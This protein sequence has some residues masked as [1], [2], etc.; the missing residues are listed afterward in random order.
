MSIH[1]TQLFSLLA[2]QGDSVRLS[3]AVAKAESQMVSSGEKN[4]WLFWK[5]QSLLLLD[6]LDEIQALVDQINDPE[7]AERLYQILLLAK[8]R[9]SGNFDNLILHLEEKVRTT[10]DS[11]NLLQLCE[12]YYEAKNWKGIATHAKALVEQIGTAASLHLAVEGAVQAGE[13]RLCLELLEGKESLFPSGKLPLNLRRIQIFSWRNEG[14]LNVAREQAE[15]LMLETQASE[16]LLTFV[17]LQIESADLKGAAIHSRLLL[18]R[19]DILPLQHLRLARAFQL[20]DPIIAGAHLDKALASGDRSAEFAVEAL[21]LIFRLNREKAFPELQAALMQSAQSG[22]KLQPVS[23][24]RLLEM[25]KAQSESVQNAQELYRGGRIPLHFLAEIIHSTLSGIYQVYFDPSNSP[26]QTHPWAPIF[27]R[28]GGRQLSLP[29]APIQKLYLDISALIIAHKLDLLDILE[30]TFAPCYLPAHAINAVYYQ[31][32]RAQQHQPSK[33]DEARIVSESVQTKQISLMPEVHLEDSLE[34]GSNSTPGWRSAMNFAQSKNG[35]LVTFL[36]ATTGFPP[37]PMELTPD[38]KAR[39]IDSANVFKAMEAAGKLTSTEI[40]ELRQRGLLQSNF[41]SAEVK[42]IPA[43]TDLILLGVQG[44]LAGSGVLPKI[45]AQ[46]K[47][48]IEPIEAERMSATLR[49]E[50]ALSGLRASLQVLLHKLESGL[51]SKWILLPSP[52]DEPEQHSPESNCILDLSRA[53]ASPGAYIWFDDRFLNGF[54]QCGSVPTTSAYEILRYLHGTQALDAA[55]LFSKLHLLREA[56]LRY[57]PIEAD[58]IIHHLAKAKIHDNSIVETPELTLLRR[59]V[60]TCLLQRDPFQIPPVAEGL[61]NPAGELNFIMQVMEAS[62]QAIASVWSQVDSNNRS[63]I[64]AKA[65]WIVQALWYD[66]GIL[67]WLIKQSD[68]PAFKSAL[69]G[70]LAPLYAQ[71]LSLIGTVVEEDQSKDTK[72]ALYFRWLSQRFCSDDQTMKAV[73]EFLRQIFVSD[74]MERPQGSDEQEVYKR[75]LTRFFSD[76]PPIIKNSLNL[77]DETL[78]ELRITHRRTLKIEDW[79]FESDGFWQAVEEAATNGASQIKT[80]DG[81]ATFNIKFSTTAPEPPVIELSRSGPEQILRLSDPIFALVTE[82]VQARR[83]TLLS[84]PEWFDASVSTF[85][86]EVESLVGVGDVPELMH[87]TEE[88]REQSAEWIYGELQTRRDS[89]Q[90]LHLSNFTAPSVIALLNHL[91]VAATGDELPIAPQLAQAAS[92][93]ILEIGFPEAFHRFAKLPI[94]LPNALVNAFLTWSSE[95]QLNWA[96]AA[97]EETHSILVKLHIIG[98]LLRKNK[99]RALEL[100]AQNIQ[101][102][103]YPEVDALGA[104]LQWAQKQFE[105]REGSSEW[106]PSKLLMMSWLHAGY[107]LEILLPNSAPVD[108]ESFFT[109]A[110]PVTSFD[111]FRVKDELTNDI[112]S[113]RRIEGSTLILQALVAYAKDISFSSEEVG[114]LGQ[115]VDRLCFD[116]K[117]ERPLVKLELLPQPQWHGDALGSFLHLDRGEFLGRFLGEEKAQ[118]LST[119]WITNLTRASIS[120]VVESPDN[121]LAEWNLLHRVLNTL[122]PPAHLRDAMQ[123]LLFSNRVPNDET[124]T[125][126]DLRVIL[127]FLAQQ[128]FHLEGAAAKLHEKILGMAKLFSEKTFDN[129]TGQFC[130]LTLMESSNTIASAAPTSG[131]RAEVFARSIKAILDVWPSSSDPIWSAVSRFFSRVP[132]SICTPLW[133]LVL[134]LR[135]KALQAPHE[136]TRGREPKAGAN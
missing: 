119:E 118:L 89:G 70:A 100:I 30:Q 35:Y 18:T 114:Q 7:Q 78:K 49:H 81:A 103:T 28:H 31:L 65:D 110:N 86:A 96:N 36:P 93:L 80:A 74:K 91:R 115:V 97:Y 20:D 82:N 92:T 47:V 122:P 42:L 75:V 5:G 6:R 117:G 24:E 25:L 108:L 16:D 13:T 4:L 134:E 51:G 14:Q 58:E 72:R 39:A 95:E 19:S 57:L 128:S 62:R 124:L 123:E 46:Y 87:R 38:E 101:E 53:E 120:T 21:E 9:K 41:E 52:S 104:I 129:E 34:N 8:S 102:D 55:A 69:T 12:T 60:A 111:L 130:A 2:H 125:S 112:C 116:S 67:A 10:N 132:A 84:H 43:G 29:P 73:A 77:P 3:Q 127:Y 44:V 37:K 99:G 113:P 121:H 32:E 71:G 48:W 126:P 107:I 23:P 1:P 45:C 50:A 106:S 33:L 79:G 136:L 135:S 88:R 133:P 59:Y 131:E 17:G 83:D 40:G 27:I 61:P 26:G 109:K 22:G 68:N 64:A 94:T 66:A 63:V 76:L 85:H 11:F 56:N 15:K 90:P 54:A 105:Q 98:L